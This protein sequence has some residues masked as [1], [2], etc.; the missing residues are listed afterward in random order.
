MLPVATKNFESGQRVSFGSLALNQGFLYY[1]DKRLAWNDVAKIQLPYN[2]HTSLAVQFQVKAAGSVFLPWCVVRA[3]GIP[4][5]MFLKTL[6][7][8]KKP[9]TT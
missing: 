7:E 2:A 3:Q 8:L 4:T 1:K 9:L 5:W 6:V